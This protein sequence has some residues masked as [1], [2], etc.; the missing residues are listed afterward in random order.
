MVA[1]ERL[2]A[3]VQSLPEIRWTQFTKKTLGNLRDHLVLLEC[4]GTLKCF[5][6][7]QLAAIPPRLCEKLS[8]KLLQ[9]VGEARSA[10]KPVAAED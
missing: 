1:T 5:V 6:D 7:I 4:S 2:A 10:P 8:L 3:Q 9:D